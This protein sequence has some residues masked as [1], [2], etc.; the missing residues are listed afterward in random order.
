VRDFSSSPRRTA[1]R[2]L[3]AL[4][5]ALAGAALAWVSVQAVRWWREAGA[6]SAGVEEAR[7]ELETVQARLSALEARPGDVALARQTLLTL[8]APPPRVLAA[9]SEVLPADVR[10]ASVSLR[11]GDRLE[12]QM[13]VIARSSTAYDVFLEKL[14]ASP[15]FESVLPGEENRDGVVRASVR[16]GYRGGVS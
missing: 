4:L 12:L 16:A 6:R 15:R 9:L 11:Y 7:R 1:V 5:V 2:P 13:E 14:S 8:D 10:L 3:D